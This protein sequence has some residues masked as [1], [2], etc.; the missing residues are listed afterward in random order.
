MLLKKITVTAQDDLRLRPPPLSLTQIAL[1]LIILLLVSCFAQIKKIPLIEAAKKGDYKTVRSLLKNGTDVHADDGKAGGGT[2]LH[3]A[4]EKGHVEIVELLIKK[5]ADVNRGNKHQATPLMHAAEKGRIRIVNILLDHGANIHATEDSG[6][7]SA[8]ML[9][10][11]WAKLSTVK[12]L[13]KRGA[14]VHARNKFGET[15]LHMGTNSATPRYRLIKVLLSHGAEVNVQDK[16]GRT[17]LSVASKLGF[18]SIVTMFLS[19]GSKVNVKEKRSGN[20]PLHHVASGGRSRLQHTKIMHD[21]L[22]HG[23]DINAKN[24]AGMTPLMLA[25]AKG[26][27]DLINILLKRGADVHAKNNTGKTALDLAKTN[28]HSQVTTQLEK[29]LAQP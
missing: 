5:G 26:Y 25:S 12:T 7:Y 15:P 11:S 23:A 13:L 16:R 24:K 2:A 3:Y 20:T 22:S 10:C 17:P 9:A 4:S 8:L 19:L 29:A 1:P 21:L 28:H 14:D 27:G 6:N 18:P